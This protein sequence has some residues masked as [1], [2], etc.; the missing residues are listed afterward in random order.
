MRKKDLNS[1]FESKFM[2]R[3]NPS[4]DPLSAAVLTAGGVKLAGDVAGGLLRADAAGDAA[5]LQV[6]AGDEAKREFQQGFDRAAT[7]HQPFFQAGTGALGQLTDL[8]GRDG[9]RT[10]VPVFQAEEFNIEEDP[11]FQFRLGAG[12]EAIERSASARGGALGGGTLKALETFRQGLASEEGGRAYDRFTRD[13]A[14]DYGSLLDQYKLRNQQ[15]I[16][17]FNQLLGVTGIGQRA[18]GTLGTQATDL[19]RLRGDIALQQGNIR[20]AGRQGEAQAYGDIIG[21]VANT[22]GTLLSQYLLGLGGGTPGAPGT[23]PDLFSGM[24]YQALPGTGVG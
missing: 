19:G 5:D 20:A 16:Q 2:K 24:P 14:F 13:R 18:A 11:A 6:A 1:Y 10:E 7:F 21:N 4:I 8:L 15:N 9:F 17:Q 22:G 12:K 23:Q 3:M